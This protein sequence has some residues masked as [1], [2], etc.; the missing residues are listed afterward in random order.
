M[1][2]D[3]GTRRIGV[4][5]SDEAGSFAFPLGAVDARDLASALAE[6]AALASERGIRQLVVGLPLHMD[7]RPGEMAE[8]ARSFGR[9]LAAATGLP[10]DWIDERWTTAEARRALRDSGRRRRRSADGDLDASAA[11]LLLR[12]WLDR[13]RA[14]AALEDA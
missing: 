14:L 10:V 4:A 7:G 8:A 9:E 12:T 1:G 3:F 11:A 2:V 5:A 6:L 13:Q